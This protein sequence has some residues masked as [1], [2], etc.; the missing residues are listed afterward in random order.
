MLFTEQGLIKQGREGEPEVK[1]D[2]KKR[3]KCLMQLQCNRIGGLCPSISEINLANLVL[4]I[5]D[6]LIKP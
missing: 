1:G 5:S 4:I 6:R 2:V 3:D